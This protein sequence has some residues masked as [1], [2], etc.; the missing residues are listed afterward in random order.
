MIALI[1]ILSLSAFSPMAQDPTV[2]ILDNI[3]KIMAAFATL[4]GV[5]ALITSIVAILLRYNIIKSEEQA[6]KVT[7]G[8]N[9]VAF[10][11]LVFLGVFRPDLSLSFLDSIAA[12]L[13]SIA[14]FVLGFLVQ[15]A[16][17]APVMRAFYRARVP[18][19]GVMGDAETGP[20]AHD[21]NYT[22]PPQ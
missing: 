12:R 13:A 14:L 6:G 21:V 8:L 20:R 4:V 7:A 5:S 15:M 22:N 10:I 2:P 17:P 9:L 1:L 18:V 16:T 19:L 3:G 11:V